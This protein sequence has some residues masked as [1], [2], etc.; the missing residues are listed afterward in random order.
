MKYKVFEKYAD[1]YKNK[2]WRMPNGQ[3]WGGIDFKSPA[4][5][6]EVEREGVSE[7]LKGSDRFKISLRPSAVLSSE[8][9]AGN[10]AKGRIGGI[11]LN[12][13]IEV[14]EGHFSAQEETIKEWQS[15]ESI[16]Y[17]FE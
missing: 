13:R 2:C 17:V 8:D 4:N 9:L 11:A 1:S 7:Y 14:E 6:V 10:T 16:S 5:W 12:A 15:A 3:N